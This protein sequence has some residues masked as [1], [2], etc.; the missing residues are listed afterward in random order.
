MH[1]RRK[2]INC[3]FIFYLCIWGKKERQKW[4]VCPKRVQCSR[5]PEEGFGSPE[6]E[7]IGDR[8][9]SAVGIGN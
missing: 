1:N 5:R 7:V 9:L 6:T 3:C 8:E 4:S 2:M